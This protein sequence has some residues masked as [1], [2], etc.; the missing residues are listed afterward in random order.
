MVGVSSAVGTSVGESV[1][2]AVGSC[3]G[4]T[5]GESVGAGVGEAVGSTSPVAVGVNSIVGV[6]DGAGGEAV[7]D[8]GG[9]VDVGTGDTVSPGVISANTPTA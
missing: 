9:G 7:G 5:V 6:T 4:E 1:P 3:V 2:V 8:D